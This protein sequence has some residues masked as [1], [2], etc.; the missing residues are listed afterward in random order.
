M[1]EICAYSVKNLERF[2]Y[3][4]LCLEIRHFPRHHEE[5]LW[6][7]NGSNAGRVDLVDHVLR[8][9]RTPKMRR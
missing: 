9:E 1:E 6:E 8:G 7:L 3:L 2:P 5:K 4:V